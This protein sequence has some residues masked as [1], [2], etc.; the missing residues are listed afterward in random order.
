M[1]DH[2]TNPAYVPTY[3]MLLELEKHLDAL[4]QAG[5]GNGVDPRGSAAMHAIRFAAAI[6]RPVVPG[7]AAPPF[8]EDTARLL[9]LIANWRDAALDL[10]E[11]APTAPTGPAGPTLRVIPGGKGA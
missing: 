7:T 8:T 3:D 2:W 6:L 4:R 1:T 11:F 9:W 10:G 5:P